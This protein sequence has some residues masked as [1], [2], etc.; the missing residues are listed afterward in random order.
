MPA[1]HFDEAL[2]DSKTEAGAAL[3]PRA[4][5]VDLLELLKDARMVRLRDPGP[6]VPDADLEHAVQYHRRH[7]DGAMVGELDGI[8]EEVDEH[9]RDP[10]LVAVSGRES[11]G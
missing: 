8:A 2:C 9:L 3:A 11:V 4:R 6:S 1:M 5:V 7:D 10:T